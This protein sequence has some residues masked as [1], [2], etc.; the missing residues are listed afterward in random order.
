MFK[1]KYRFDYLDFVE[2]FKWKFLNLKSSNC[3]VVKIFILVLILECV[4]EKLFVIFGKVIKLLK[5]VNYLIFVG[6]KLCWKKGKFV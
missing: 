6:D 2:M 3:D 1:F 5:Y 4:L